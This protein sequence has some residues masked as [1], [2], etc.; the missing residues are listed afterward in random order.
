LPHLL[1]VPWHHSLHSSGSEAKFGPEILWWQPG[2]L[3]LSPER[4]HR[5]RNQVTERRTWLCGRNIRIWSSGRNPRTHLLKSY[6]WI[7]KFNLK[8]FLS[9]KYCIELPDTSQE[10]RCL[11]LSRKIIYIHT[12]FLSSFA[13]SRKKLT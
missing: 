5:S 1:Q 8:L 2:A 6:L 11:G 12:F 3:K 13:G 9:H 7:P 10:I 4:P